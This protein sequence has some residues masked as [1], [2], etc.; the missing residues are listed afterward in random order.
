M[1]KATENTSWERFEAWCRR[2]AQTPELP[3]WTT[4]VYFIRDHRSEGVEATELDELVASIGAGYCERGLE[5]PTQDERVVE[6]LAGIRT[7]FV[8][9][10]EGRVSIPEVGV[11]S[12][13]GTSELAARGVNELP[14][15]LGGHDTP[16]MR[17]RVASFYGGIAEMFERWVDRCG[18]HNTR[19]AYR[20]DVMDFVR[21]LDLC[22][23]ED[24]HELLRVTVK[25]VQR[26]R[27]GLLG[28]Q[29][30]PKTILRRVCSLSSFYKF[31]AGSAAELRLPVNLPNPAHSQFIARAS[32]D[33]LVET[34][35]LTLS[36]ARQLQELPK[37]EDVLAWR[38]RAILDFYLYTGARIATGCKLKVS[39]FHDVEG[40]PTLR[41]RT[42]G[43]KTKTIGLHWR[44][45][46]SLRRYIEVAK[47]ERG[48][49]FRA[50]AN[51][52]TKTLSAEPISVPSMYRL[53]LSYLSK[54]PKAMDGGE[55]RYHPHVLRATTATLLLDKGEDI[56]KVQELLGHRHVTTTQVYDK[57]RVATKQ[58]A[59]HD[60]PI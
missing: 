47:L 5:D 43:D 35:A 40:D 27:D 55:C 49:L 33:P 7:A 26:W 60:V 9:A 23:P 54:L 56:R 37:G 12:K 38:D 2:R 48:A 14:P 52:R 39:D 15:V 19:R 50:R 31:L 17:A 34:P 57:R 29:R 8:D 18:G 41:L 24:A 53:L 11:A 44:A 32:A 1:T 13:T 42:K 30:A 22:W 6:E 25:D 16:S 21:F 36:Q 46:D 4:L 20:H 3:D 28:A 10:S 45:A 59:S 58:G 51:S